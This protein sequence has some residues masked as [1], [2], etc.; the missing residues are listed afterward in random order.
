[1]QIKNLYGKKIMVDTNAFIYYLTDQCNSLTVEIFEAGVL[2]KLHLLTT[3]RIIDELLFK[4]L[5]IKAVAIY[6]WK[7][8]ILE[9]LKKESEKIKILAG[10]CK[11]VL[12]FLQTLN[13]EVIEIRKNVIFE[14]PEVMSKYGLIGNDAITFK[15][16][17]QRNLKYILTADEDFKNIKELTVLNPLK[18]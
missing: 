17:Q 2:K 13:V 8:K 5:L 15:V 10:V 3:I 1:M 18:Q 11:D 9:K 16:M 7:S 4:M 6:G 14:I 12:E